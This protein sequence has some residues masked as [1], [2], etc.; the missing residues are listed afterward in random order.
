MHS[1][2]GEIYHVYVHTILAYNIEYSTRRTGLP[3]AIQLAES[4]RLEPNP[5][6]D[7]LSRENLATQDCPLRVV[8]V[9]R[10]HTTQTTKI[11]RRRPWVLVA[12]MRYLSWGRGLVA[13]CKECAG[14]V[15]ATIHRLYHH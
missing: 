7:E 8:S 1:A 2:N 5:S 13:S 6:Q 15:T 11:H 9:Y 3:T 14:S 4:R 10:M 12:I